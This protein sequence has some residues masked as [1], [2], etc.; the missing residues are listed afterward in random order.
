MSNVQPLSNGAGGKPALSDI[1]NGKINHDVEEDPMVVWD[2]GV[3]LN[4]L[5]R[6]GLVLSTQNDGSIDGKLAAST[7]LKKGTYKGTQLALTEIYSLIEEAYRH[8][9]A[10]KILRFANESLATRLS[11]TLKASSPFFPSREILGKSKKYTN[12]AI[13]RKITILLI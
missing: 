1:L 13:R 8:L 7:G 2:K 12:G 6:Q 3:F 11:L 10:V 5:Q 4:E 9:P